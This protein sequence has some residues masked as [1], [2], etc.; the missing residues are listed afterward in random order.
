MRSYTKAHNTSNKNRHIV[1]ICIEPM[2]AYDNIY[3]LSAHHLNSNLKLTCKLCKHAPFI[4]CLLF[5]KWEWQEA[6]QEA[7]EEGEYVSEW[8]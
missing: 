4:L 2:F 6:C 8:P 7:E 3:N 5:L 1:L